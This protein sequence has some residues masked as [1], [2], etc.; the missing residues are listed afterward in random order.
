M[1]MLANLKCGAVASVH[2][3]ASRM[4]RRSLLSGLGAFA[5]LTSSGAPMAAAAPSASFGQWVEAFRPRARARGISDATYTRVM[6]AIKPDT[7]VY[8]LDRAQP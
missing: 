8:A 5:M 4:E 7:S 2:E 1:A 6:G 3:M